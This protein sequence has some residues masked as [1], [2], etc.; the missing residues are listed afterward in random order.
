MPMHTGKRSG[1]RT[2]SVRRVNLPQ[3]LRDL[4]AGAAANAAYPLVSLVTGPIL[5]RGLGPEARGELAALLTP[6]T[7]ADAFAAVGTPLAAAYYV[8][9]GADLRKVRRIGLLIVGISG[10]V[11]AIALAILADYILASYA[12][13]VPL[14]RLLCIGVALGAVIEFY[15]GVRTGQAAYGR[16]NLN[17]WLGALGRL[18]GVIVLAYLGELTPGRVALLS[19]ATGLLAALALVRWNSPSPAP[20]TRTVD[21]REMTIFSLRTWSGVL[22]SSFAARLDQF[23]LIIIVSSEEL[24]YYAVAVTAAQVPM[25]VFP[26]LQRQLLNRAVTVSDPRELALS[27][28]L[29]VALALGL[30]IPVGLLM[31]VL[32]PLLFGEDF[33]ESVPLAQI[34]II[35]TALW[36]VGQAL[37]GLLVGSGRPGRASWGDGLGVVTLLCLIFPMAHWAGTAGAATALIVSNAL[38]AIFK[39]SQLARGTTGGRLVDILAPRL[40]DLKEVRRRMGPSRP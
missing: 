28:R 37:T 9:A 18:L 29:S 7:L 26:V 39:A 10:T 2:A 27:S 30:C 25:A 8:R 31:P 21:M 32:I 11:T 22:A 20:P 13:L 12:D 5:A 17:L 14:F 6:L 40:R 1:E 38:S 3:S 16:L 34:L 23:L 15:R 24:G 33:T 36:G 35:A 19:I 4:A